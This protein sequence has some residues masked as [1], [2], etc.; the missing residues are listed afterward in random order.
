MPMSS[1]TGPN[2]AGF[3][4]HYKSYKGLPPLAGLG[5]FAD[6]VSPGISVEESV[7]RLKRHH[8]LLRR[9]HHILIARLTGEPIYELKMGFS[10]HAWLCAEIISQLRLR[11]GEMREPP[12][13]LDRVPHPALERLGD[14]ALAAPSTQHLLLGVYHVLLPMVSREMQRHIQ[15]TNLLA[16]QP[17]RRLCLGAVRDL[18]EMCLWGNAAMDALVTGEDWSEAGSW[19]EL[20][21][22]CMRASESPNTRIPEP[23]FS[24]EPFVYDAVPKRDDRFPDPYNM[25]VNAEVFL[26]DPEQPAEAKVLMMFYKRPAGDRCP[27]DDGQ[28]HHRNTRQTMGILP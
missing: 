22:E 13:G 21:Q 27:R 12:L 19:L 14:E 10:Y 3:V 28:H 17:T 8:Y 4:A 9:V 26:Y 15:E 11:V 7:A 20:L 6:A 5:S 16:D 2:S 18:D 1:S 24:A 25:G 23:Q